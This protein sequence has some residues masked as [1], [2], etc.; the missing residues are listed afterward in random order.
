MRWAQQDGQEDQSLLGAGASAS[1]WRVATIRGSWKARRWDL[2]APVE[3]HQR[4]RTADRGNPAPKPY[5]RSAN[6]R[7]GFYPPR[8][9]RRRISSAK[10]PMTARLLAIG[11][12]G[13]TV[14]PLPASRDVARHGQLFQAHPSG[15][16][17]HPGCC[18]HVTACFQG[19]SRAVIHSASN[20]D[21]S[22]SARG[23]A[24][25]AR[26]R[27]ISLL[28]ALNDM[29]PG[30]LAKGTWHL[31]GWLSGHH[32]GLARGAELVPLSCCRCG[33]GPGPVAQGHGLRTL[34][35]ARIDAPDSPHAASGA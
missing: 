6:H 26:S 32:D 29:F 4:F 19:Q 22:P 21:D 33:Q 35:Y 7:L 9:G 20:R 11:Q 25:T 1:G 17:I 16:P 12:D 31:R 24:C 10:L 23:W 2:G 27:K 8:T 28:G 14:L 13:R 5:A 34:A 18:G 15:F 30:T 3:C